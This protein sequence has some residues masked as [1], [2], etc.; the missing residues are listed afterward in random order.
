MKQTCIINRLKILK[1]AC[2]HCSK[3][4]QTCIINKNQAKTQVLANHRF[5]QPHQAKNTNATEIDST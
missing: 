5:N 3:M 1:Q 4:K 2:I